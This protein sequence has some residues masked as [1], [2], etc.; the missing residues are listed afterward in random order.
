[1]KKAPD[2]RRLPGEKRETTKRRSETEQRTDKLGLPV[3]NEVRVQEK[4]RHTVEEPKKRLR[5]AQGKEGA[6]RERE[7]NSR[8]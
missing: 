8:F 2:E 5:G 4:V 1:M 6:G 3:K 7:P